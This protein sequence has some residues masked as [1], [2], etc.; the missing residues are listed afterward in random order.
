MER[1][2]DAAD[3]AEV[4]EVRDPDD[5]ARVG[6]AAELG[7]VAIELMGEVA[8][9]D[10]H[11]AGRPGRTGGVLEDR[12]IVGPG[13]RQGDVLARRLEGVGDDPGQLRPAG[14]RL[15]DE[16][17]QA[18]ERARPMIEVVGQ[19]V[20]RPRVAR[21]R[22][23]PCEIGAGPHRIGRRDRD[24]DHARHQAT[25]QRG[26]ELQRRQVDEHD[27]I[28]GP[29]ACRPEEMRCHSTRG[30]VQPRGGQPALVLPV[31]V[32]ERDQHV[33][34]SAGGALD[35]SIDDRRGH[36]HGGALL[37]HLSKLCNFAG[38]ESSWIRNYR[39]QFVCAT[40]P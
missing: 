4:V 30:L 31:V 33:G 3:Q 6:T 37:L 39:R 23:E 35:Q 32:D 26:D 38:P 21:E 15:E 20:P 2:E 17:A 7:G 27:A 18:A 25:G 5:G 10:H 40:S 36:G 29:E 28:A 14:G 8:V 34:G 19:R 13:S 22:G 16:V 24:G 11:A 9:R 1:A 12:Q